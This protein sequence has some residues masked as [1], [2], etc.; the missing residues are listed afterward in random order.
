MNTQLARKF[1]RCTLLLCLALALGLTAG[2]SDPEMEQAL[3]DAEQELAQCREEKAQL[4]EEVST[5]RQAAAKTRKSSASPP[6]AGKTE[7]LQESKERIRQLEYTLNRAYID[8]KTALMEREQCRDLYAKAS[9]ERDELKQRL[10][11][12]AGGN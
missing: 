1:A 4:Q 11:Q 8:M 3:A 9:R 7:S 10:D 5:L 12:T 6:V 2:C